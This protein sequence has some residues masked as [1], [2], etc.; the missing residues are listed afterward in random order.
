MEPRPHITV[1]PQKNPI[2]IEPYIPKILQAM[3]PL[4]LDHYN[5][6]LLLFLKGQET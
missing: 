5:L 2:W 1:L 4:R 6:F 3:N